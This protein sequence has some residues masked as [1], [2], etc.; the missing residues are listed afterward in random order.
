MSV[1]LPSAPPLPS[2]VP[3][4]AVPP[5]PHA[6][7]P[8]AESLRHRV[9]HPRGWYALVLATGLYLGWRALETVNLSVWWLSVPLLALEGYVLVSRAVHI[10]GLWDLDAVRVSWTHGRS[11][12]DSAVYVAVASVPRA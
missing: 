8:P 2:R 3:S 5:F 6:Q 4:A 9:R 11:M 10:T 1:I 7:T 12:T